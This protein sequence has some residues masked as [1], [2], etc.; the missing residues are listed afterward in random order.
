[1]CRG[2][3]TKRALDE[4]YVFIEKGTADGHE[5]RFKDA[6]DE[7]VNV[8]AGEVIFK[9]IQL[10]HPRFERS[11]DNLKYKQELTLRQAMLGFEIEIKHLDGHKV[12]IKR[13]E[14]EIVQPGEVQ[15][16]KNE[17]MPKYGMPSDHGDL[18]VTFSIRNPDK[19]EAGQ[20]K[21]LE[22]FF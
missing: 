6:A 20:K 3:K 4:L 8:R 1:M 13:K 14:G 16:I 2:A 17:G 18:I 21:M 9:I 19:F 15:V 12:T 7:Y 22:Q 11:G 5:E 10:N